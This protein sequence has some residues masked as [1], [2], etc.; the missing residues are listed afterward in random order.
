MLLPDESAVITD[1]RR[2]L[3]GIAFGGDYNPEQWPEEVWAEDARLMKEAGVNLVTVGVFSW[4]HVQSAPG[5]FDFGWLD[6]VL[7]MLA[8]HGVAVD[9]AT[10]TASPPPWLTARHPEILPVRAD[11]VTLS[12]GGRQH[13]NPNSAAYREH[14][15]HLV[16]ALAT[17]YA[18]H[19]ALAMWHIGNEYG[20]HVAASYDDESAAAFRLWLRDRYTDIDALNDAWSTAFWSQRYSD[21]EQILPP[22][23]A[24]TF[25][26][27]AQQ[28]DFARFS[29]EALLGC[30]R[31][32]REILRTIT[33]DVPATT[34]FL[35]LHKP[36][37]VQRWA[38][39]VDLA[40]VDS[41]PDP[42]LPDAHLHAGMAYDIIRGARGGQPWFLMEHVLLLRR[43]R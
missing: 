11:G 32:E 37:S 14:A 3:G 9:L 24:P 22:R 39:H 19:P 28:L 18:D 41:Y 20:I 4:A 5:M 31:A 27:P 30:Y 1:L 8:G 25:P 10:M 33:P 42:F 21:F 35:F 7:D 6:R 13:F 34:N 2:R 23:L 38:P 36:V 15:A 17:R 26:N 29:D 43:R 16:T 12:P 40:S